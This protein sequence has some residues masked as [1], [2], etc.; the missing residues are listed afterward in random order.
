METSI[1]NT[2]LIVSM[3]LNKLFVSVRTS[4]E[5]LQSAPFVRITGVIVS[6]TFNDGRFRSKPNRIYGV[7]T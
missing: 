6:L 1:A 4:F 3:K 2:Q 5:S 7:S